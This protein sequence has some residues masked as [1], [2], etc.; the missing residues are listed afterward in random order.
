MSL[1][2]TC[3]LLKNFVGS[4]RGSPSMSAAVA[5][6]IIAFL[7]GTGIAPVTVPLSGSAKVAKW[8][9]FANVFCFISV[10]PFHPH[11]SPFAE[12]KGVIHL[13]NFQTFFQIVRDGLDIKKLEDMLSVKNSLIV[14]SEA[15][16][17]NKNMW[18]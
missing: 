11:S 16:T 4:P 9:P 18:C 15:L 14:Q 3:Y 12:C 1:Y 13:P 7:S 6:T 8:P 2:T 10:P 17:S 5:G